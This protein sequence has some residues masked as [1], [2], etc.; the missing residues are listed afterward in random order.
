MSE[1]SGKYIVSCVDR[2]GLQH[3]CTFEAPDTTKI[4]RRGWQEAIRLCGHITLVATATVS[5]LEGKLIG[6]LR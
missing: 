6:S 2:D 5:T 3:G 4:I 1:V